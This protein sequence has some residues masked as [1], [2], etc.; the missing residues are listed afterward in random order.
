MIILSHRGFW[1]SS[2]EKNTETAFVR[3]FSN[4]FGAETDVR[5]YNGE[6]VISHDIPQ[7]GCMTLE[8]FLALYGA[9]DNTLPL[10]L[11]I[12]SDGL[13]H[14]LKEALARHRIDR[15][16][17]FDMSVPDTLGY[18]RAGLRTF[19]RESEYETVPALYEDA[20]GIW[21]DEFHHHWIDEGVIVRHLTHNKQ[22]CIVSPELHQRDYLVEW[23]DYRRIERS[24]GTELMLCTD[25]PSEAKE[26]FND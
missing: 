7:S 21:L 18:L 16:F 23:E 3:S 24:A 4:G 1:Q 25:H 13:Q 5:D 10:A 11:N 9:C 12:K 19:T 14:I 15:Y 22:V 17:V 2:E 6:L 20:C 8:L 26:Y